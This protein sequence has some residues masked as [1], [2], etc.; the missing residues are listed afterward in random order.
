MIRYKLESYGRG[1][2]SEVTMLNLKNNPIAWM[3][4]SGLVDLFENPRE[5]STVLPNDVIRIMDR[6]MKRIFKEY[7]PN[8]YPDRA[9]YMGPYRGGRGG[10]YDDWYDEEDSYHYDDDFEFDDW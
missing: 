5:K 4:S 2:Y 1:R 6:E 3:D 9:M 7:I 10:Y 8:K